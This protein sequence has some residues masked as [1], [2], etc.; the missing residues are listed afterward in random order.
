MM[1]DQKGAA[2]AHTRA[3]TP[4][5][6]ERQEQVFRLSVLEGLT[7]REIAAK[8]K[9][10]KKTVARDIEAEKAM[11]LARLDDLYKRS[12]NLAGLAGVGGLAAAGK[13]L[14]MRARILGLDAP[15]KV[16]AGL[17][18]LLNALAIP[19]SE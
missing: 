1:G 9:I 8:L 6:L 16:D 18:D 2:H 10:D 3:R 13:A 11:H 19:D 5:Q 17:A 12:L 15:T 7:H 14:E 4:K